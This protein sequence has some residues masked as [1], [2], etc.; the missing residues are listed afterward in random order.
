VGG[1]FQAKKY[2]WQ[3][4]FDL[5]A[6]QPGVHVEV[7]AAARQDEATAQPALPKLLAEAI[8]C[9]GRGLH[10]PAAR[11]QFIDNV[12]YARLKV[13]SGTGSRVRVCDDGGV[14]VCV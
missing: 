4:L 13:D 3:A 9:E 11:Q 7:W 6:G 2:L 5:S 12:H 10:C 8:G 14:C 1:L